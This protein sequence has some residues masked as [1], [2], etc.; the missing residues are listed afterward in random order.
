LNAEALRFTLW[1]LK[2]WSEVRVM[3]ELKPRSRC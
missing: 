1:M 3:L 2:V